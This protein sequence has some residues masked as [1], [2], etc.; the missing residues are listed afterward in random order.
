M[1]A[2]NILL[3]EIYRRKNTR[4]KK[5]SRNS[6]KVIKL[7]MMLV[8][9][10]AV[11]TVLFSFADIG[12]NIALSIAKS[13]LSKVYGI[14]LT[15]KE[16]TGNPV[17][18]YTLHDFGLTDKE[19]GREIFSA[20]FLTARVNL[21]AILTGN[22]R[23]AEVS[24]G[25]VSMDV[26]QFTAT[27]QDISSQP[28]QKTEV[29]SSFM[30]DPAFADEEETL[31]N[32]PVDRFR[33]VDSR[34]SSSLFLL[35]VRE[36]LADIA[37]F[38]VN[39]DGSINGLPLRGNVNMDSFTAVNRSELFLGTGKIIATGGINDGELDFHMSAEDFDLKE[40]ASIFPTILRP[41][42]FDG[43]TD[44]TADITGSTDNPTIA[45][46]VS[47]SGSKIYGYPVER[48][49]ANVRYTNNRISVS[50]I[51]ASALN[52]PL[53]GEISALFREGQDT[54]LTV[55]LE[56]NEATL[57]DMDEIL[58]IPELK[59]L[60]GKVSV[61]S[62]NIRGVVNELNGLLSF[63]APRITCNGRAMTD[64]RVQMKL[65]RSD[66][67]N[68]E[69]KFV[70]EEAP[71]YI[72]GNVSSILTTPMMDITAKIA[73]LDVKRVESMIA[74][75]PQ[76]GLDGRLTA[77]INIAGTASNPVVTGE[78]RSPE[79]SGWGHKIVSPSVS[80]ELDGRTLTLSKTEGTLNGMPVNI[81]GKI[82]GIPSDNPEL[83][84]NATITMS[85]SAL[86][87]YVPDIEE[88]SLKGT[89]NAGLKI[90]GDMNNPVVNLLATSPNLQAMDIVSAKNLELTTAFTGDITKLEQ[91]SVN[92][93]A[94]SVTAGGITLTGANASVSKN[95]DKIMLGGFNARSGKGMVTGSGTA[96]LSGESPL[97]FSFMFT[98]LDIESLASSGTGIKGKLSGTL[99][100]AGKNANPALTF[101][102]NVPD[103]S[104][105]F[106]GN[107]AISFMLS[108]WESLYG[109]GE[110]TSSSLTMLGMKL[111]D[112]SLPLVYSGDVLVS[113]GGTARIYGGKLKNSLEFVPET[114]SFS[115]DVDAEEIDMN[116]MLQ[117]LS[118]GLSGK[119]SGNM[120]LSLSVNGSAKDSLVYTGNGRIT[121][122]SGTVTGFTWLDVL[123]R[124]YGQGGL[125]FAE[126]DVPLTLQ[127]GK[128]TLKEGSAINAVSGDAMYRYTKLTEDGT[129]DFSGEKAVAD[130]TTES[131]VDYQLFIALE[132]GLK[133]GLAGFRDS[134]AAFMRGGLND[135][136][137]DF[138]TVTLKVNG[139]ADGLS[140]TEL[141]E[142][143]SPVKPQE[144]RQPSS[145]AR[146][147][148]KQ[149]AR[150]QAS[151]EKPTDK[152][153][154]STPEIDLSNSH[155]ILR[156]W[157]ND[158]GD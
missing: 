89:V 48:A 117:D 100:I 68:V 36:I 150:R 7:L 79:F 14:T 27:I 34:F 94:E 138:R 49:S 108:G 1:N 56:G 43:K 18:G 9:V 120:N 135:A 59:T 16:I 77:S 105:T 44:F 81:T 63:A 8:I 31:P 115:D 66:T 156:I 137:K 136:G 69:G 67:A 21:M 78:V 11:A 33:I 142:A 40:L 109:E 26:E 147:R 32:I 148:P 102:A 45:G 116:R 97:D 107:A 41:D 19:T 153:K 87:D 37:K 127:T 141:K 57:N 47:Y 143:E 53:Q 28:P 23:L 88:Y 76:Y 72:S 126:I 12:G 140:F 2:D 151:R 50:N 54:Y 101:T 82:S 13:Q 124:L 74:D 132:G 103:M 146:A 96:S 123:S 39:I 110:I 133:G 46:S 20:G 154:E 158:G 51:Q 144:T 104:G 25:G 17:R 29:S 62:V 155:R 52:I 3:P 149:P 128:V 83:D 70:F 122:G 55:R 118:G 38:D 121:S 125:R 86:K 93:S 42:D 71:G 91:L 113:E 80:F 4:R 24:L 92:F 106:S 73:S 98:D 58:G 119:I 152:A 75:A 61:F 157:G 35:E 30:A 145:S 112:V 10:A 130:F 22:L 131:S 5:F 60:G 114:M 64:I 99:K 129:I 111:T 15:A 95:G 139:S 85:N 90:G 134:L 6:R 84:I 65:S